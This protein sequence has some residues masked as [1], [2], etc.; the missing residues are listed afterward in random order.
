MTYHYT[1]T[2]SPI[3]FPKTDNIEFVRDFYEKRIK[4]LEEML[5]KSM[6]IN[7]KLMEKLG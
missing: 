1:N 6:E 7:K 4:H 3:D 5:E 2:E